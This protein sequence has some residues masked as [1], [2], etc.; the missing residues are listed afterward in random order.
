MFRNLCFGIG[1]S[2]ISISCM[3]MVNRLAAD[4]DDPGAYLP[5]APD[6]YGCADAG[7][8]C[9]TRAG[10]TCNKSKSCTCGGS[11]CECKS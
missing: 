6:N 11:P 8:S 3:S 7:D 10:K 2:L 5:C 4:E 1:I 9:G